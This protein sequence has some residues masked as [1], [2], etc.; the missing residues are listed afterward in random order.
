MNN[1]DVYVLNQSLEPVG[2]ID[3]YK[4]LI[5]ATRY[6]EVGDCEL[7][8]EANT[9]NLSLLQKNFYLMRLD[10]NMVCQI[11]KLELDTDTENGNYLTVTGYDVKKWLDQRVIWNTMS[12]DGNLETFIRSMVDAALGNSDLYARQMTK[13]D[14]SRMFYLGD[15]AGF[16]EVT[17]EQVS[18]K[19]VGE[20]VREYCLKYGWGYRVIFNNNLFWF[21]LYKGTDRTNLVIFS[22]DY[23]NL[24]T[25][26]YIE[27][28]TNM[29]NVALVA[30]EGQGSQRT[31]NVAGDAESIDRYEIYIDAKDISKIITWA[32]LTKLY[33]TVDQG[34]QGYVS[35]VSESQSWVYRMNYLNIQIIDNDQLDTLRRKYPSGQE[36]TIDGNDYYQIYNEIIADIS[37]SSP[38]DSDSATLRDVVYS[39]Y[40]ITRGYEKLAEY[41]A[42]TSFEGTV[43]PN[44]TF[45][46][47]TDYFLGDLVTVEN[48][49]GISIG[50]RITEVIEVNDENGYNVEPKFEYI[51]ED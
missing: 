39:T 22:N 30:A 13:P 34:G 6:H 49:Y 12:A 4:S 2:V 16:T 20:K 15:A 7:Y 31:R 50:A 19:N 23:E 48:E 32:E 17:T 9:E 8:V 21:Q 38:A 51:Q 36:I 35:Y 25:T 11:K 41:G 27:D 14:G 10:D 43:E 24:S 47:K 28:V 45:V 5:W 37:S 42:I 1:I 29:G 40:L 18:Y 26:A 44:T 3:S 46:Y 33:P